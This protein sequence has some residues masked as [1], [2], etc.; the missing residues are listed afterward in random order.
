MTL[1]NAEIAA[2]LDEIADSLE[3]KG[4]NP[5]R[6]RAYRNA[7]RVVEGLGT[8]VSDMLNRGEDLTRLPGIGED[9]AGKI[10]EIA[11][12]GHSSTLDKLHK[13]V[14][15]GLTKLLKVPA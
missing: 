4:A 7:A 13:E 3:I 15:E 10:A 6:V 1:L 9:L 5:F 8:E 11:E 2:V 14:P 12:S